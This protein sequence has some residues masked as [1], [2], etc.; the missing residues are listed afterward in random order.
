M[1]QGFL[2]IDPVYEMDV[3][4]SLKMIQVQRFS[5][6]KAVVKYLVGINYPVVI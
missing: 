5:F 6:H 2:A 3:W 4:Q 1:H